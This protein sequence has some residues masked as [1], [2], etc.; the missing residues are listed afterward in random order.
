[1]DGPDRS[2][3]CALQQHVRSHDTRRTSDQLH[4]A[5]VTT[6]TARSGYL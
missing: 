4:A 6:S 1:M 3:L 2:A 5:K